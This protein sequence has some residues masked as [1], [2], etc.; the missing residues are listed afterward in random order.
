[1]NA[2][3]SHSRGRTLV[4]A[5]WALG[6]AAGLFAPGAGLAIAIAA[7]CTTYR[8]STRLTRVVILALGV[9]TVLIQISPMIVTG[10][11]HS[12]TSGRV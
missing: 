8:R 4:G 7:V 12:S 3:A 5:L 10:S 2:A 6:I 9:L 1:M 11:G